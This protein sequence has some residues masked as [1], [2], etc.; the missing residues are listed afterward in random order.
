MKEKSISDEIKAKYGVERGNRGIR[1]S[2]INDPA[3]RFTTILL[4][5]KLMHK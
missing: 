3:T 4:G 5:C 2:Y 1:M